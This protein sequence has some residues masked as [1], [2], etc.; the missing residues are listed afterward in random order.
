MAL[1]ITNF[2]NMEGIKEDFHSKNFR[3][4]ILCIFLCIALGVA[5]LFHANAVIVFGIIAII[6]GALLVFVEIPFLLKICPMSENF[7]TFVKKFNQNWP[8]AGF[9]LV[10]S[11]IQWVSLTCMTT[12]LLVPAIFLLFSAVCYALAAF[13]HQKFQNSAGN[14]MHTAE[15]F[16]TDAAIREIL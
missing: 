16:P 9:Y 10:M 1:K 3:N 4:G 15:T 13:K 2:I 5:N 14:V 8:R 7:N 6:Q 12:S 11:I